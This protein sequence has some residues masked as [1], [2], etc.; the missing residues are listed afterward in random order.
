MC[1]DAPASVGHPRSGHH[2]AADTL[3]EDLA[4]DIAG[5]EA[6]VTVDRKR[7]VI[8]HLVLKPEAAE[9]AIGQIEIDL[10]AQTPLG[11]DAEAIAHDQHPDHQL[12]IDRRA[13]RTAV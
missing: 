13:A 10:L 2:A 6:A 8:R 3:L 5:A 7:R 11:A 9:P 1:R 4:Q 12:R